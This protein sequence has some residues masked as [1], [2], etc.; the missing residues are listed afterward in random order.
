MKISNKELSKING[1]GLNATLFNSF[2]R[3]INTLFDIGYEIGSSIR[4]LSE[5]KVCSI[6]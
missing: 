4:R 1:G 6:E 3:I 5:K 2:A